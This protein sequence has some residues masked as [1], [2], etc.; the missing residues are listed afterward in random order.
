[1]PVKLW[2]D[3]VPL[4]KFDLDKIEHELEFEVPVPF[5]GGAL[6]GDPFD[7][8]GGFQCLRVQKLVLAFQCGAV[9]FLDSC[10][11][12]AEVLCLTH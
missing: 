10:Y 9:E 7:A 11:F 2:F 12:E 1:M 4:Q 6:M 5:K 3:L 8:G